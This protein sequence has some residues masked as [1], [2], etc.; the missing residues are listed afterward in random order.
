MTH[1]VGFS[2]SGPPHCLTLE[3]GLFLDECGR[4]SNPVFIQKPYLKRALAQK[5][6]Q[7]FE[8][9][10]LQSILICCP[11]PSAINSAAIV[12]EKRTLELQ[13]AEVVDAIVA[14]AWNI[15]DE[16]PVRRKDVARSPLLSTFPGWFAAVLLVLSQDRAPS[17][18]IGLPPS[19][20]ALEN[21]ECH[22]WSHC[23]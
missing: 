6:C 4:S 14:W 10:G 8:A 18:A 20:P 1:W 13:N 11:T 15:I 9:N 7:H 3:S 5:L 22:W 23:C 17:F 19:Q 21:G 12:W 16:T 2:R